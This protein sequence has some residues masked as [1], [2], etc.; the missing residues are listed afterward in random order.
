MILSGM[1]SPD[2]ETNNDEDESN[3]TAMRNDRRRQELYSPLYPEMDYPIQEEI[4]SQINSQEDASDSNIVEI[5][6][7]SLINI[8]N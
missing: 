2:K 5:L 1:A 8:Y 3:H 6:E 4:E 7:S